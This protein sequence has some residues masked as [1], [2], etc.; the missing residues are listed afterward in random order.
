LTN[1]SEY[2]LNFKHAWW[3]KTVAVILCILLSCF[4][5]QTQPGKVAEYNIK[6]VFLYNFTHFID[7]PPEALKPASPFV[8]GILGDDP[9]G[10]YIDDAVAGEK[11]EG[12]PIVVERYHNERD[13]YSCNI[14][15][16][17]SIEGAG[18]KE[19]LDTFHKKNILTVSDVDSFAKS[20]GIIQFNNL[21]SKT[22]FQVNI[23]AAKAAN[24]NI[25]SKLLRLAEVVGQ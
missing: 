7:W 12:H 8:I 25:S 11:I 14:L 9:F 2:T 17:T 15:F 6:A 4:N 18:M 3:S 5:A 24:L 22:R 21:Q 16:I 10:S 19:L 20:G 13:A 23:A 1:I